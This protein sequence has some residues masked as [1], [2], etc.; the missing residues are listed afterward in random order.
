MVLT[1]NLCGHRVDGRRPLPALYR[2]LQPLAQSARER[3]KANLPRRKAQR[4]GAGR[5]L[6]FT[7]TVQAKAYAEA[8]AVI[9]SS[10]GQMISAM[11]GRVRHIG[12]ACP[13]KYQDAALPT[14]GSCSLSAPLRSL[15]SLRKP[16]TSIS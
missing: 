14:G 7:G 2:R 1:F 13:G 15:T 12:S 8:V 6:L 3:A 10:V 4:K 16:S 5:R 9:S 11:S